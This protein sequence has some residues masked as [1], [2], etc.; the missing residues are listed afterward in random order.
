MIALVAAPLL[1][2]AQPASQP[3]AQPTARHAPTSFDGPVELSQLRR[4]PSRALEIPFRATVVVQ[5]VDRAWDP[6]LTRFD[7]AT[8]LRLEAWSDDAALWERASFENPAPYLF[9]RRGTGAAQALLAASPYDRI[10]VEGAVRQVFAGEPWIEIWAVHR[11]GV[12]LTEATVFHAARAERLE[13]EGNLELA[14]S[15]I[16]RAL[17]APMPEHHRAPLLAIAE[18]L[19]VPA[20]GSDSSSGSS[21]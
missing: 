18:R 2:L 9:A 20:D 12:A 5:A 1:C 11:K 19:E 6:L 16:E 7:G 15:E 8:W 4:L 17:A 3:A 10:E 13:R 14:R 21:K